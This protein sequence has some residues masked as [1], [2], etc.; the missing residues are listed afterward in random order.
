MKWL[1]LSALILTLVSCSTVNFTQPQPLGGERLHVMPSELQGTWYNEGGESLIFKE[2]YARAQEFQKDSLGTITDTTYEYT[3]LSDSILLFKADK[4]FV[5]NELRESGNYRVMIAQTEKKGA[6]GFYFCDDPMVYGKMK[7]LR[8][9][10]V[11]AYYYEEVA[12]SDELVDVDTLLILPGI[13][14]LEH[15]YIN[16]AWFGGQMLPKELKKVC[17]EEYLNFRLMPDGTVYYPK[18]DIEEEE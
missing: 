1:F 4:Y 14:D 15:Y 10:S 16:S 11:Q 18:L 7:S 13:K 2:N 9:D 12:G 6:I 3:Y 8:M 5:F 17:R